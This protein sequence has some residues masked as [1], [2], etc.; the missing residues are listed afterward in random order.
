MK[1]IV[2]LLALLAGGAG[3][4]SAHVGSPDVSMEGVAGPY[5]L[6][7]SVR[8]P[9]VIPG[10]AQVT[11]FIQNGGSVTV[12]AQP[13]FFYSGRNGAPSPDLLPA[14][15][16]Q[17]GQYKGIVWMMNDGSSSVL[18]HV[19]GSLGGGDLVVPIV[20]VST[21]QK[22]LPAATGYVLAGLGVLLFVLMLTIIGSSVADGLARKGEALTAGRRRSKRVAIVVAAVF[23]S[24]IVYGGNAWWQSWAARY[25]RFMYRPMHAAYTLR[26]DSGV[27]ALT[28][29]INT[30]DAQRKGW[31]PYIIP[32]HGKL[33]HLFVVR[34]PG[35]DA[36]AHLHPVRLDSATFRTV[37][38]PLPKGRYLAFADIVNL[39]GFAET[40]KDTFA[41]GQ[42]LVDSLH[43][44][45]PDDAYAFAS[46]AGAA[47]AGGGGAADAVPGRAADAA[48]TSRE[49]REMILCGQPGKGVRMKDGSTMAAEG[50][51]EGDLEAGQLYDL[52]FAVLGADGKPAVLEPYLGMMAHAAIIRDDGSTYVHLHPVGTYSVAAQE[53]LMQRIGEPENEY[54]LPD[55]RAFSDSID[56]LVSRLR[57]MPEK[58]RDEWLM[59][60]MKMPETATVD[61]GGSATGPAG[62]T[63][64]KMS[65]MV[66]FPYT[67]PQPGVYRI[68][69]QVRRN[70]EVLTAAFDRVVR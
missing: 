62:M 54:R 28:I 20:A 53:G 1:K 50:A 8:P 31:L 44:T 65:N 23:S 13:I 70:G 60:K 15:A 45:D 46:P 48:G 34:I 52:R 17:P 39:S 4:L 27:N 49:H 51:A 25:R 55:A 5:R 14:V 58:E 9:D 7:V 19:S 63:G 68:W 69:V 18:L 67:F 16:G 36:F 21:A 30:I 2:W 47:D 29:R 26:S 3:S 56:R 32:D 22:K 43:H 66:S 42:D 35:M 59:R 40:L 6:L 57:G 12:S 24:L 64:M 11:V 33:M 10:T 41:I 38:P 61:T 37:L